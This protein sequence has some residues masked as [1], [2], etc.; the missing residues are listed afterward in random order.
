MAVRALAAND[1]V[2]SWAQ[3][4]DVEVIASAGTHTGPAATLRGV[5]EPR[6]GWCRERG[7]VPMV[8]QVIDRAAGRG[9]PA[10]PVGL[11]L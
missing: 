8:G 6:D 10:V 11:G 9:S 5:R 4:A 7:S 3:S 1:T 2:S